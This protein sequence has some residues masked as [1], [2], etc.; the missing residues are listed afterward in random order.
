MCQAGVLLKLDF[1][2]LLVLV[3]LVALA[4]VSCGPTTAAIH[5]E[6]RRAEPGWLQALRHEVR[7]TGVK[8]KP[9]SSHHRFYDLF[10]PMGHRGGGEGGR[11]GVWRKLMRAGR[12]GGREGGGGWLEASLLQTKTCTSGCTK[13]AGTTGKS[14]CFQSKSLGSHQSRHACESQGVH[15]A[16]RTAN[17]NTKSS[18]LCM[19]SLLARCLLFLLLC[20]ILQGQALCEATGKPCQ[21]QNPSHPLERNTYQ[22][23]PLSS[24]SRMFVL[25]VRLHLKSAQ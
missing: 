13:P 5:R 16:H 18:R 11:A 9:R 1:G 12:R 20:M 22:N 25:H 6:D 2:K 15:C 14:G 3:V 17:E 10:S 21:H 19:A 23:R 24:K 4:A 8:V 7:S